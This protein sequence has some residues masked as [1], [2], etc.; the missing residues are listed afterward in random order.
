MAEPSIREKPTTD[1]ATRLAALAD[2]RLD[3]IVV[4]GGIT[5]CGI[6]REATLRGLSVVLLEQDDFAGGTSSRSSRLIHGGV[7]YLEHGHLRLVFEASAE[8]RRLL[9]LAPHLVQPLEFTWPVY[10]GARVPLWKLAAGLTLYDL[11]ALFRNVGRHRR[12]SADAVLREQPALRHDGLTGG[13][14]Y[15][16]ACTDD[17]RLT[18][19]V[20]MDARDRGAAM[21]NHARVSGLVTQNGRVVGVEVHDELLGATMAVSARVIVNATGPWSD[22][23]RR[24]EGPTIAPNV[25]GSKGAHIAVPR[26]RIGNNGALTVLSPDDGRVMFILPHGIHTIIGTT[27]TFT[28]LAPDAIR[29][30]EADVAYLLAAANNFFPSAQLGR[31]DVIAAWAG[32]RPLAAGDTSDSVAASREHAIAV[33]PAGVVTITG[34]KL[35]TFRVMAADTVDVVLRQLGRS[36]PPSRS[37]SI[38][39]AWDMSKSRE[40]VVD[41]AARQ[42]GDMEL[43]GHLVASYGIAWRSAWRAIET[44][45]SGTKRI[46]PALP[47]CLGE[48][49]YAAQAEMACTLSD[50]L[51]RRTRIAFETP[52]HGRSIAPLVAIHVGPALGWSAATIAAEIERYDGEITRIFTVDP[53]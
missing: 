11:L 40:S 43:A 41:E 36:A 45:P 12:L 4:G 50:L 35:T 37:E 21:I 53:T 5:G 6:A 25:R 32:I 44:E 26:E 14:T 23:F 33:T 39:L 15:Y 30:S 22:A 51:I 19:A 29:A 38:A 24:L 8:R 10:K 18:L 46:D 49:H 27:D 47:Y 17:A 3:V 9:R 20:A 28:G 31:D 7:R 48:M 42:T 34:G 1:R 52:D 16:D 2:G 13:A